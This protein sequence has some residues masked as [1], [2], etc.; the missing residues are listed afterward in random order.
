M[1]L[2]KSVIPSFKKELRKKL[3]STWLETWLEPDTFSE[4]E[5]L[6]VLI[7]HSYY[8]LGILLKHFTDI[9]TNNIDDH[10]LYT[11]KILSRRKQG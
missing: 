2:S 4:D 1:S 6:S 5:C 7:H 10:L 9:K 11:F 8:H 3:C